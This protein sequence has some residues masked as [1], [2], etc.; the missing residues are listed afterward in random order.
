MLVVR[1]TLVAA[2]WAIAGCSA[3]PAG[4]GGSPGS[5]SLGPSSGL[6]ASV[7]DPVVAEIARLANVASDQVTVVSAEEVTF[8]DGSLGC[9]MPGVMYT[10]VMTDGFKIIAEAGGTTYDF[11]GAG[12]DQFRRCEKPLG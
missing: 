9:P 11:R 2:L 12:P 10:Q 5:S 3:A 4:N 7:T 1:I 6:P 8:P